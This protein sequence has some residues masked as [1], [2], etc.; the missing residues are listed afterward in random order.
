MESFT[1]RRNRDSTGGYLVMEYINGVRHADLR[2]S[3]AEH[4]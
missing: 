2:G 4:P 3:L 1:V